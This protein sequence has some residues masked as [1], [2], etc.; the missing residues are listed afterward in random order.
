MIRQETINRDVKD[1]KDLYRWSRG[2][3]RSFLL[4]LKIF[5]V[6]ITELA[7]HGSNGSSILP[8]CIQYSLAESILFPSILCYKALPFHCKCIIMLCY[9]H[10]SLTT[11]IEKKQRLVGLSPDKII[12]PTTP[13]FYSTKIRMIVSQLL[14]CN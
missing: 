6:L 5:S 11:K 10:S 14:Q 3:S 2:K 13:F 9:K 1:W 4:A 12:L 7:F 8:I